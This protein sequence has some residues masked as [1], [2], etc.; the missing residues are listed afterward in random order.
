MNLTKKRLVVKNRFRFTVFLILL[1]ALVGVT[2]FA[3]MFPGQTSAD[4]SHKTD[5]VCV[6]AGD[7]LWSI[8]SEYSDGQGDVR[9]MVYRIKALNRLPSADLFAGQ[10]LLVPLN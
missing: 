7:T 4:V 10:T 1:F 8:A 5:V 6:A 2:V 3:F 9:E